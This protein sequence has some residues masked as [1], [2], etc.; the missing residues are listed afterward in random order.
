MDMSSIEQPNMPE[1]TLPEEL[2][3]LSETLYSK[4]HEAAC[5]LPERLNDYD[6]AFSGVLWPYEVDI[7]RENLKDSD[8]TDEEKAL[9][10]RV[11]AGLIQVNEK[12]SSGETIGEYKKLQMVCGAIG[13][14]NYTLEMP[15]TGED[16]EITIKYWNKAKDLGQKTKKGSKDIFPR[17]IKDKHVDEMFKKLAHSMR[18][19]LEHY[20][21]VRNSVL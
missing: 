14:W 12:I 16:D 7:I 15:I 11:S 4:I 8:L 21:L 20:T 3:S 18:Y 2:Y 6:G 10:V 19:R 1:L 5:I 17:E 9:P 13:S